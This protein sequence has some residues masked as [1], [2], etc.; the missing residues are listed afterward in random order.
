MSRDL[1]YLTDIVAAARLA[2]AYV[3]E[4]NEAEFLEDRQVQDAVIRRL[5][6]IGEAARWC[7]DQTRRQLPD[8]PWSAIIGMRNRLI[9]RYDDV[10][11]AIVWQTIQEH[12]PSLIEGLEAVAGM[13][14][15]EV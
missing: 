2:L 14:D 9:H 8:I 13:S 7:S 5:E 15:E 3:S 6:I 1:D 12:L 10:D 4:M 11:P